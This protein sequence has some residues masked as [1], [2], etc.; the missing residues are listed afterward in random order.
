MLISAGTHPM[1]R[2]QTEVRS[3]YE[4]YAQLEEELQDV[5][6]SLLILGLHVH[7]GIENRSSGKDFR[8]VASPRCLLPAAISTTMSRHSSPFAVISRLLT[9]NNSLSPQRFVQH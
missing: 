7:I 4:R 1:A 3:P 9:V 5:A 2:W 8:V 6:R